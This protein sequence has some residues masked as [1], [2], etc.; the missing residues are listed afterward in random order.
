MTRCCC[1]GRGGFKGRLSKRKEGR[2]GSKELLIEVTYPSYGS[3]VCRQCVRENAKLCEESDNAKLDL[4]VTAEIKFDEEAEAVSNILAE[5]AST[6]HYFFPIRSCYPSV[7]TIA[8]RFAAALEQ[9][10]T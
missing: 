7:D 6:S 9:S 2:L 10:S 3:L 1:C 4:K 8:N 5:L